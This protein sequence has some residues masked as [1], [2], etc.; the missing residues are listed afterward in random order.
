MV[1][2]PGASRACVG[3]ANRGAHL[4]SPPPGPLGRAIPGPKLKNAAA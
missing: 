1:V 4:G 2:K 3:P